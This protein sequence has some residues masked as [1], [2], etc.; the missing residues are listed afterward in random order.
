MCRPRSPLQRLLDPAQR[1][2]H[3]AQL[4][5]SPSSS[6]SFRRV[7][8]APAAV[9][10]LLYCQHLGCLQRPRTKRQSLWRL[11]LQKVVHLL[12]CHCQCVCCPHS[13]SAKAGRALCYELYSRLSCCF[14][15]LRHLLGSWL[16]CLQRR[17]DSILLSNLLFRLYRRDYFCC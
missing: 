17:P 12:P 1:F 11:C 7:H 8:S 3:M 4:H 14:W 13:I 5:R 6:H 2:C 10:C 16:F 9:C 15:Q